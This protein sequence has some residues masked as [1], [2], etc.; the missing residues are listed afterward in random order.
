MGVVMGVVMGAGRQKSSHI[1]TERN[2]LARTV[3]IVKFDADYENIWQS[4]LVAE[5]S[6]GRVYGRGY[7]REYRRPS[8][9]ILSAN[10]QVTLYFIHYSSYLLS[11]A[12]I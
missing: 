8:V 6:Y 3:L 10:T 7:G 4:L 11:N 12:K 2:Y 5:K 1:E 9:K